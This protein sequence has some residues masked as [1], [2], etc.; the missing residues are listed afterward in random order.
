MPKPLEISLE[1]TR[2]LSLNFQ[3]KQHVDEESLPEIVELGVSL[4][5]SSNY[6]YRQKQLYV[7]LFVSLDQDDIP[8][9]LDATYEGL[10]QLSKRPKKEEVQR[11]ERINC[12][13]ILF[14]FLREC[15]AEVTRRGGLDPVHLPA[16]NFVELSKDSL[17]AEE[18]KKTARK[19][20]QG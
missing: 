8:F 19:K 6:N 11:L 18:R 4:S 17:K 2:L 5:G 3:R 1:R 12:P 13:A 16:I 20:K 15:I 7:R 9:T 10:F 14:P